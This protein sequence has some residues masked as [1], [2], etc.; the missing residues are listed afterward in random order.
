MFPVLSMYFQHFMF[1]LLLY[2]AEL[3]L[4][5]EVIHKCENSADG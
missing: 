1:G 2:N 4:A 3:E 5:N